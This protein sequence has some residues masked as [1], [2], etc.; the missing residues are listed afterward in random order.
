MPDHRKPGDPNRGDPRQ[1]SRR[2]ETAICINFPKTRGIQT[3]RM[4]SAQQLGPTKSAKL[5]NG[6]SMRGVTFRCRYA[7]INETVPKVMCL[8]DPHN[9]IRMN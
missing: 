6:F 9:F 1:F 5:D 3:Y 8:G 2:Y 7:G 4:T